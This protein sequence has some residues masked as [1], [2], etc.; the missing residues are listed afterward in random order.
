MDWYK[1]LSGRNVTRTI[2]YPRPVT[3]RWAKELDETSGVNK[4]LYLHASIQWAQ[5]AVDGNQGCDSRIKWPVSTRLY[6]P[7]A[8]SGHVR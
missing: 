4:F 2:Q 1:A 5:V 3:S 6:T 7:T 8:A